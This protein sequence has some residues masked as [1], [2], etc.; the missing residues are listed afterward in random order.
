MITVFIVFIILLFLGLPV[1]FSIGISGSLYF[2]QHPEIPIMQV[3]QLTL[4]QIQSVSLLAVPLFIFAGNLM[5]LCGITERLLGLASIVTRHMYGGMAQTSVVLSTLMGGISG[6]S[7]ADA[8]MESRIL[9]PT[10]IKN[11][12]S[13]GYTAVVIGYTSLITSTIPPGVNLIVYGTTGSVSV[14]RMFMAGLMSGIYMMLALMICV[15]ITSK[16]RGYRPPNAKRPSFREIWLEVKTSFWAL[17]FPVLLLVG[18]RTG[19]FTASEV[20]A[21]ACIY[22]LAVGIIVY[23]EVTWEKMLECLRTS[24]M[25]VG[26]IMFMISL[27]GVFGYGIPV[28]KIPQKL[29]GLMLSMTDSSTLILIMILALLFLLGMLMDGGVIVLLLTP[30]LLPVA[31]AIGLDP[32]FFGL[33]MCT[34]CCLGILTPPVGVAMYIVCG[35]LKVSMPVWIKESIPFLITVVLVLGILIAFPQLVTFLPNMVYG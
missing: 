9:G 33:L 13:R 12:Y 19:L 1:A 28:E 29:T 25:D 6:S 26:G 10:M 27:T 24:I 14:G 20:G 21:F 7:T 11:G 8:A 22:A 2:F 15:H 4:S 30:M 17:L 16:K 34:V 18:I 35:N 5:N 23:R 31:K 32:V 3:A